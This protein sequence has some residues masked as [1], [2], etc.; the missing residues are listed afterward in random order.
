MAAQAD[1]IEGDLERFVTGSQRGLFAT[2]FWCQQIA[3][4]RKGLALIVGPGKANLA[5]VMLGECQ[6]DVAG[7]AVVRA[8][9]AAVAQRVATMEATAP[10][11]AMQRE[12]VLALLNQ[13]RQAFDIAM[14][15]T[16]PTSGVDGL[17]IASQTLDDAVKALE[18]FEFVK[19]HT[20][21]QAVV[22]HLASLHDLVSLQRRRNL[23]HLLARSRAQVGPLIEVPLLADARAGVAGRLR[24]V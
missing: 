15:L 2:A 12:S 1:R 7:L 21:A 10:V 23:E 19:A 4:A 6:P 20:A 18:R 13:A 5:A 16:D 22:Q 3:E 24:G 8:M 14:E 17:E 9:L 11:Q